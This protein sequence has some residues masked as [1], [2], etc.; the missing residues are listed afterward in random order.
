MRFIRPLLKIT[1]SLALVVLSINGPRPQAAGITADGL[2][3]QNEPPAMLFAEHAA[4]LVLIDGEPVYR[5]IPGTD[6]QQIINTKPFIVRDD[7]GLHYIKVFD[8][9]MEAYELTGLWSV[10]GVAP[11]GVQPAFA[12]A[13]LEKSVDLLDGATPGRPGDRPVLDGGEP[14]AIFVSLKP[15]ELIVT[16]GPPRFVTIDGSALEYVENTTANVFKEPTDDELYVLAAG[17]WFRAWTFDGPW[18]FVPSCELPADIVAI[19]DS[20]PKATVK[21]STACAPASE[22]SPAQRASGS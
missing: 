8:G 16:D 5:P 6:L 12:R 14:P 13:V 22:L 17:R 9:W 10:S 21:T 2:P 19:P 1:S 3:V 15:A 4:I 18:E 20:S 7:A 11:S